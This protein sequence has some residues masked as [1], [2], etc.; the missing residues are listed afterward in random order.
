MKSTSFET[1]ITKRKISGEVVENETNIGAAEKKISQAKMQLQQALDALSL[2]QV[3]YKS[4]VITNLDLLD[5][6]TAVSESRLVLLKSQIDYVLNVYRLK[7]SLGEKL[8]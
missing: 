7:A 4:G 3:S 6:A 5:A 2:A 1:E 8:Y